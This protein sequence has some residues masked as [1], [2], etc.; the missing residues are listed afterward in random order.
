MS[1]LSS[2]E[3]GAVPGRSVIAVIPALLAGRL[4]PE[5][6]PCGTGRYAPDVCGMELFFRIT[7]EASGSIPEISGNNTQN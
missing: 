4:H 5:G 1:G 3:S 2:G 7:R 6:I